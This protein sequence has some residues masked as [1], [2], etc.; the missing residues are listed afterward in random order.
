[1]PYEIF[2]VTQCLQIEVKNI[3]LCLVKV[4]LDCNK[5]NIKSLNVT[6]Y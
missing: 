3:C 2:R 1:V 4:P 5:S 6:R